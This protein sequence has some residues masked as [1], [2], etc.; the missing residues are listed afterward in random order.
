MAETAAFH[1]IQ[2]QLLRR[3]AVWQKLPSTEKN[4]Y[5]AVAA[6]VCVALYFALL[7]PSAHTRLSKLE[8]D[9]EK[10]AVRNKAAAKQQATP[11]TLAPSLGG[12]NPGE[13]R[14]ELD[15]LKRQLE[16]ITAEVARLNAAFVPIDDSLAMNVL[17]TGLTSLA[18]AGD[19]EVLALEHV[20]L[21][22]EDKDRSPTPEMVRKAA[23][24]NPFKRPLIV[25]H[26]RAS[27]RG[28]MQ[29]LDGLARLPYVAAPVSSE[30]S[31]Q[32][33]RHP[34]TQAIIRQWL[35]VQIKFAV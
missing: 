17:K 1:A 6:A 2:Q 34:E 28:L 10:Q 29:F 32:V 25:M 30:I 8:Y 9:L 7:W 23:Q 31:V 18:E 15:D 24:A 5:T 14:R 20:Y 16:H 22:S 35:D 12:R 11:A 13:A 33:E 3:R 27:F 26:A 21:H 19:M 4:T